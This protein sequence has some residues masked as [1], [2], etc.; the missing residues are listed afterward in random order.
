MTS[1]EMYLKG[2]K[3]SEQKKKKPENR[4]LIFNMYDRGITN[5]CYHPLYP[6]IE[7]S[8]E[9]TEPKPKW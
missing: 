5:S 7:Q 9:E 1:Q 6:D 2:K 8:E 4:S 3:E